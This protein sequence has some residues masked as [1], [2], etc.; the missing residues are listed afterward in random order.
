MRGKC[1]AWGLASSLALF[2]KS[3]ATN[4]PGH[5]AC[6]ATPTLYQSRIL[7]QVTFSNTAS[8]SLETFS[9][10]RKKIHSWKSN[11]LELFCSIQRKVMEIYSLGAFGNAISSNQGGLTG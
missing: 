6:D 1:S 2:S 4:P 7:P 8:S 10:R 3:Q 11:L 5:F 9:K